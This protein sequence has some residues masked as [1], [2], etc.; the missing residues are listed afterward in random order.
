[1]RKGNILAAVP[2]R[3][4]EEIF[5]TLVD[6][7]SVRIERIIS[8]AHASPE[9]FQYDQDQNEWVLVLQGSAA[10]KCD[11]EEE[12]VLLNPGDWIDIP[13]HVKHRVEWTDPVRKTVWLAV[14]Y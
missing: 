5:E 7:G 3:A 9:G 8:E 12:L 11:L 13:A 14:F 1:M 4:P 6:S 2:D 10:L